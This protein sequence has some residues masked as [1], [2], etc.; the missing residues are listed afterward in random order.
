MSVVMLGTAEGEEIYPDLLNTQGDLGDD[1]A[2]PGDGEDPDGSNPGDG[3][4]PDGSNPG[5]G[6]D[7]DGSRPDDGENDKCHKKVFSLT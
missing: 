3:E 7:P 6:E 1:P 4:D 5:G 2:D